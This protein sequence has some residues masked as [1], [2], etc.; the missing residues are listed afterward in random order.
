MLARGEWRRTGG[1]GGKR[2]MAFRLNALYSPW[3]R[4]GEA[5]AEWIDSQRAPEKL[6]NF[7]NS[8]LGE[9]F[10]EVERTLDAQRLLDE[11]ES[12]FPADVVPPGTVFLTGGVDVQKKSFFWTVRAWLSDLS[13]Y[14]VA[15]GQAFSWPEIEEVMNAPYRGTDGKP[16][17]V[18]LA[19]IDSGD[20]TDDVY[21]FCAVN[22]PGRW[23]SRARARG[24]STGIRHPSSRRTASEK[25]CR[26]SLWIPPTTRT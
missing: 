14:N 6:Q 20:Q 17:L 4:F 10:R 23:R 11:N 5:A 3:V 25:G 13:S 18:N 7:V 16:M 1:H 21:A 15:H 19:A 8:W 2:R 26:S 12:S 24:S 22:A 9:P